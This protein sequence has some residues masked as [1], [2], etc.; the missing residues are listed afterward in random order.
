MHHSEKEGLRPRRQVFLRIFLCLIS[1]KLIDCCVHLNSPDFMFM[2][3]YAPNRCDPSIEASIVGG[4][5]EVRADVNEEV[6]FVK[7]SFIYLFFGGR[8]GGGRGGGQ[9]R[10]ERR[11][12]IVLKIQKK[13]GGGG[14]SGRGGG[15]SG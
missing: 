10:C 8:G 2:K 6:F 5:G 1:N 9:G 14:G 12:E 13:N 3:H 11:S 15:G 4:R 7:I